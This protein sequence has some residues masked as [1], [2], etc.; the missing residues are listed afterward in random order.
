MA[1]WLVDGDDYYRALMFTY[2]ERILL[3]DPRG[4]DSFID[5]QV[6]RLIHSIVKGQSFFRIE[7]NA[8]SMQ[9]TLKALL[10][11]LKNS[12]NANKAEGVKKLQNLFNT[13]GDFDRVLNSDTGSASLISAAIS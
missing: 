11:E 8:E 1:E 13:N 9:S 2:I 10:T 12:V 5:K 4:L 6:L 7:Q 3:E